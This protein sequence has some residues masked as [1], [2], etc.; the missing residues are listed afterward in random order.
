MPD[1][2]VPRGRPD[3][4]GRLDLRVLMAKTESPVRLDRPVL[5]AAIRWMKPMTRTARA[6]VARSRPMPAPWG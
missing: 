5:P 2:K 4:Q 1:H 6:P 3:P